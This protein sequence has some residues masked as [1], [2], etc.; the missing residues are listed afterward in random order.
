MLRKALTVTVLLALPLSAFASFVQLNAN[1]QDHGVFTRDLTTG[2]DWLDVTETRGLSYNQV[3]AQLGAGGAYAGYRYATMA[4]L[5]QLI[6]NFG[7]TA[8]NQNC[9]YTALHCDSNIPGDSL[10]IENMIRTL[11]DTYDA[12]IDESNSNLD[13]S[14]F[15]A[16]YT[17]GILGS[18]IR[19]TG[20]YDLALIYDVELVYRNGGSPHSDYDD[21]VLTSYSNVHPDFASSGR[22]RGSFLVAPSAV[23]IP[24]AAWLF[25]SALIGLVG[26]KRKK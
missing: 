12:S 21:R 14:P 10:I 24:T 9:S 1:I 17:I 13:A 11:G 7:Y 16:G 6:I 25:G 3:A 19:S 2:L 26:I 4:E 18:Q 20:Y 8:V 15:G 5:D 22:N 23:P